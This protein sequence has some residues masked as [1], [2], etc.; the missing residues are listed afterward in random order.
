ML[1]EHVDDRSGRP[2]DLERIDLRRSSE[3]HEHEDGEEY[4]P[5]PEELGRVGKR[6]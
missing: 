3:D 1:L 6:Q 4:G 5:E 2:E